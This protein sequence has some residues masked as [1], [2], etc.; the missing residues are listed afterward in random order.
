MTADP[1]PA[2]VTSPAPT[3]KRYSI[4]ARLGLVC[5]VVVVGLSVYIAMQ[6]DEFRIQR[7]AVIKAPGDVVFP[8]IN[9]FHQWTHWSPWENLD[10]N[11]KRT[12]AGPE[13]GQGAIYSWEGNSDVGAGR[14]TIQDS[15]PNE[16]VSIKLEFFKP[17]EAV[18]PTTFK[19]EPVEGGTKVTWT[20]EGKN[21]F[22]AKAMCL[23]MNMDKMVGSDFEKGLAKLDT[24]AQENVKK[25][26]TSP[27]LEVLL[28]AKINHTKVTLKMLDQALELYA[29]DHNGEYPTTDAGLAALEKKPEND[30]SWNGP[31]VIKGPPVDAW[32]KP[33]RY[34]YPS[35]LHPPGSP[36]DISSGGPD[37]VLG[38]PDDLQNRIYRQTSSGVWYSRPS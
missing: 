36:P 20:M 3:K 10:P 7:T 35:K 28:K 29:I 16:L 13:A 11:L 31:Y 6:P 25:A 21:N 26:N 12:Y 38:T 2:T 33:L 37:Q 1:S 19:L 30:D 4:L 17:F 18:S 22:F 23:F 27:A 5:L 24:V 15:Q 14:M 34:T 8:L 9:D 32:A